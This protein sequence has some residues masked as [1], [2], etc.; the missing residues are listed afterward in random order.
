M[1][2]DPKE[3]LSKKDE[4]DPLK[5]QNLAPEPAK[6]KECNQ[7]LPDGIDEAKQKSGK[8]ADLGKGEKP[9]MK[10]GAY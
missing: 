10:H 5:V 2:L 8:S 7:L 9:K 6:C 3:H 1:S 4:Q